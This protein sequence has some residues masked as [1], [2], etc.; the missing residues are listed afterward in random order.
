MERLSEVLCAVLYRAS[1]DPG[2]AHHDNFLF[3]FFFFFFRQAQ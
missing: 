3:F 2:F 1:N